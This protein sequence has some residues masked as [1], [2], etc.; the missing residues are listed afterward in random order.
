MEPIISIK[1][2][3]AQDP[4]FITLVT[5]LDHELWN[6]LMEDQATY[7]QFNKVPDIRTAVVVFAGKRPAGCGCF[8]RYDADT[9]EVKRM[10]VEKDFRGHGISKI[11]LA[12]LENWAR[13]LSYKNALLETSVHFVAARSLYEKSGYAVIENYDQYAGL[14]ESV[15]M[16]KSLE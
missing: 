7:D 5:R 2:T 10:F 1:R 4:D 15:C 13:E 8:K 16:K 14:K 9:V 6:E 12:E 11:I 3:T